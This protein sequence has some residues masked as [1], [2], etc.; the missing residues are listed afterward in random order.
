MSLTPFLLSLISYLIQGFF[1]PRLFWGISLSILLSSA[2]FEA[3]DERN[4]ICF[5][6]EERRNDKEN[7]LHYLFL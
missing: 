1:T 3:R 5:V 2:L 7:K 4:Y 6:E